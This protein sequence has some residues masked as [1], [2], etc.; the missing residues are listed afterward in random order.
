MNVQWIVVDY[1]TMMMMSIFAQ[2]LMSPCLNIRCIFH[3]KAKVRFVSRVRV[4]VVVTITHRATSVILAYIGYV[5]DTGG[6][7]Q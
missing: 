2:P 3:V 6:Y 7:Y 4:G 1:D 5:P